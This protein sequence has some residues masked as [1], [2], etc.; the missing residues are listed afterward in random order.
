M[1]HNVRGKMDKSE[2]NNGGDAIDEK[3]E[4]ADSKAGDGEQG[5]SGGKKAKVAQTPR[6]QVEK[7]TADLSKEYFR[8]HRV[9]ELHAKA[10]KVLLLGFEQRFCQQCSRPYI[11]CISSS[12]GCTISILS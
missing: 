1:P 3:T 7:C 8:R 11:N 2:R 12:G 6:C 9:C 5:R 10:R 4:A